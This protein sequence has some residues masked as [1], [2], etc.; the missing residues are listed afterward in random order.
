VFG[1]WLYA[2]HTV[3]YDALPHY[4]MEFDVFDRNDRSFL[5]TERRRELLAGLPLVSVPVLYDGPAC[6]RERGRLASLLGRSL[7]KTADW[8]SRLRSHASELGLDPVRIGDETDPS[9][10]AE[11]LYVKVEQD[12]VVRGRYK[13]I[14][15]TFLTSV[16]DSGTHWLDRPIVP[17]L[18]APGVDLFWT[19]A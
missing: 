8:W 16:L 17:N 7:Y 11:G 15:S 14:R 19:T 4:F 1:E 3:F 12:G 5:S 10:I 2:K 18:L 9:P 6:S 13:Y